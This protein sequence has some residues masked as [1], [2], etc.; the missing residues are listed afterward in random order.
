M[1]RSACGPA[2]RSISF[3][4]SPLAP[5]AAP[6]P[7]AGS[8]NWWTAPSGSGWGA[9]SSGARNGSFVGVLAPMVRS[10]LTRSASCT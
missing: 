2:S 5:A 1:S 10:L 6:Q 8:R 3:F 9:P 4:A 7:G